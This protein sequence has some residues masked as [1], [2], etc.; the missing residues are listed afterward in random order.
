MLLESCDNRVKMKN[1]RQWLENRMVEAD[2]QEAGWLLEITRRE[3]G[4]RVNG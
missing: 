4:H 1:R 2:I 3:H